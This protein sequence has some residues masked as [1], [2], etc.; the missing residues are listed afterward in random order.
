MAGA[1]ASCHGSGTQIV[2]ASGGLWGLQRLGH[3]VRAR[4]NFRTDVRVHRQ[5][6]LTSR[7]NFSWRRDTEESVPPHSK[8]Y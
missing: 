7:Q 4:R 2:W 6:G 5:V 8:V 3:L 1:A